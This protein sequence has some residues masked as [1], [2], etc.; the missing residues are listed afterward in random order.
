MFFESIAPPEIIRYDDGQQTLIMRR[1]SPEDAE[2]LVDAVTLS[3]GDLRAFMPW[4]H[5]PQMNT[6]Q[7]QRKR[8][9]TLQRDWD[10]KVDFGFQLLLPQPDGSSSLVGCLGLHP[11]CLHNQGLEIGYWVRSDVSG[12]GLCTLATKM[13]VLTGFKKMGLKRIQIAC[14]ETNMGSRRVIDK[15][16]FRYEG[17]QRN[18]THGMAPASIRKQ[19]WVG[20]GHTRS[21]ALIPEDLQEL[22]WVD[23]ISPHIRFE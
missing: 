8:L 16:G 4:S 15:V 19:G 1:A 2:D 11:R 6:V 3:L 22:D 20:T 14:D 13:S 7:S 9:E 17:R 5:F 21:Y 23:A 10:R 12:R 18:M